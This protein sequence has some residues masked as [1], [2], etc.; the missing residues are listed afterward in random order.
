[1]VFSFQPLVTSATRRSP[2]YCLGAASTTDFMLATPFSNWPPI[3]LSMLMN[4]WIAL[5]MKFFAPVMVLVDN[6]V[7][8]IPTTNEAIKN[9]LFR[10]RLEL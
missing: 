10:R 6:F 2:R 5:A 9:R 4:K 1:M 3:I 7:S 8:F